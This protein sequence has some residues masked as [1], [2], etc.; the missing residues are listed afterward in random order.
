MKN[1]ILNQRK[2]IKAKSHAVIKSHY[3]VLTFLMLVLALTGLEYD[4]PFKQW[5]M[6]TD[7]SVSRGEND[8]GNI[9]SAN[10]IISANDVI[11]SIRSGRL[12]EGLFKAEMLSQKLR[13]KETASKALTRTNGVLAQALVSFGSGSLF[14][15]M[16]QSIR[17]I[18]RSDKI[19]AAIFVVGSFLWYAFI[20]IF[21]KNVYLAVIRRVFLEAREY[22]R[23]SFL[24]VTHFAAVKKWAHASWVMFVQYIYYFLWS[25]TVIGMFVKYYSYWAVPYIVAE[26]PAISA[27]D[28]VT[29]SRRMMNGHKWELFK[30]QLTLLGWPLLSFLT[31][32]LSEFFYGAPYRMACYTEFYAKLRNKAKADQ[33]AK[34]EL[35]NDTYLF[36][37]ADRILL[38]E[39]YFSV[40]D[41]ITVLHENKVELTG[42]RQK[43][44]DWF[45]IWFGSVRL[46]KAY[47]EQEGRTFAISRYK[48][49]MEGKA[50]PQWLNPLWRKKEME[51]KSDFHYL[52]NYSVWTLFLLF[53]TFSFVGWSWEVA[54][55]FMQTGQFANRGTMYGP[56]LPIYGSGGIIVLLLCSRFRKN[57]VAEFFTAI[58]LC[59]ILEYT[60]AWFLETKYHQRWWSYDGYFLNLHGRIC[61]EGLLV[62]GIGCCVVVYLI[63]PLFDYILSKARTRILI[64]VSLVLALIYGADVVYSGQHP[65]MAEGAIEA[66]TAETDTDTDE[67][68]PEGAVESDPDL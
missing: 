8:P 33:L 37:P 28:A 20:F 54:L 40:V 18:T 66:E 52:R 53:I 57:P 55:H 61:A 68:M 4:L 11:K 64:T 51:K 56:W 45:G 34:T 31:F 63:A 3:F 1:E 17:T 50:Y 39:T 32:G 42:W 36:E 9:L 59:G 62:F 13:G 41:E 49:C 65:N 25:L 27:N 23:V 19:T 22:S 46:K 6:I 5:E 24:D 7:T 26:N 10:D 60:T 47:D 21:L 30:F 43:A 48:L 14:A 15:R 67:K 2:E 35:L 29:L 38:Y 44:A 16:A 12:D 58:G